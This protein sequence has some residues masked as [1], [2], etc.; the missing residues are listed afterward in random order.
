MLAGWPQRRL[1]LV[2][3]ARLEL[4]PGVALGLVTG[5]ALRRRSRAVSGPE[6]RLLRG[7]AQGTTL[8]RGP[9][10]ARA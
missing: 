5:Q 6:P 1:E 3:E 2:L 10:L 4:T 7:L 9:Q 8:E